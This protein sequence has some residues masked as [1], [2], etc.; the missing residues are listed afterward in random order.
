V[1]DPVAE[2]EVFLTRLAEERAR[3]VAEFAKTSNPH[4]DKQLP[5]M[6]EH[7]DQMKAKLESARPELEEMRQRLLARE[8]AKN[9]PRTPRQACPAKE[10]EPNVPEGWPL[11]DARIA[12]IGEALAQRARASAP[13]EKATHARRDVPRLGEVKEM[14]SSQWKDRSSDVR[15]GDVSLPQPVKKERPR[16][17]NPD[18]VRDIPSGAWEPEEES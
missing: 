7:F 5:A 15:S 18:E 9:K 1:I 8:E 16:T 12:A 6:L 4:V 3:V 2:L 14:D 10:K 11:S 13:A 17:P